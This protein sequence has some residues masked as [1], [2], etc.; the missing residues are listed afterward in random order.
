[1]ET[2][3]DK[4]AKPVLFVNKLIIKFLVC[5]LT[6]CLILATI[7]LV[8][9][10]GQKIIEPPFLVIDLPTLFEGFSLVLIIAIGYELVKSLLIIISSHS[11]PS[12]PVVQI[13]IIAVANKIIT[14]DV[15]HTDPYILYGLAAIMTGLGVTYFFHKKAGDKV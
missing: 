14:I 9:A 8:M 4:F 10:L 6:L 5:V 1:M 2:D 12:L 7:H 3:N 15:K 11:I 13:A